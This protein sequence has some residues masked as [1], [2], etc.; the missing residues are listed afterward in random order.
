MKIVVYITQKNEDGNDSVAVGQGDSER[1][2]GRRSLFHSAQCIFIWDEL[3][4][5]V[6]MENKS[7]LKCCAEDNLKPFRIF[8]MLVQLSS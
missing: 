1:S 4:E 3:C 7:G 6:G 8:T 5:I 2:D